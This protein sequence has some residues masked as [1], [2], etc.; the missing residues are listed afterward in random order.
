[1]D[2][3]RI[4]MPEQIKVDRDLPGILKEYT[5]AVIRANLDNKKAIIKFSFEYFKGKCDPEANG[6]T[7]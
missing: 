4:F 1:M 7:Q 5:K 3:N 6:Y 2:I